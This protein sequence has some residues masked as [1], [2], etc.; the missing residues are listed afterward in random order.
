MAPTGPRWLVDG[1][2]NPRSE[3]PDLG[4]PPSGLARLGLGLV[5]HARSP[6]ARDQSTL[7]VKERPVCPQVFPPPSP[8]PSRPNKVRTGHPVFR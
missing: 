5:F 7:G 8:I 6:K 1:V 4:H 3:N 2:S